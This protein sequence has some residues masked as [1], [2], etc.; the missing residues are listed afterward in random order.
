MTQNTLNDLLNE[1]KKKIRLGI[2]RKVTEYIK[3][4]DLEKLCE[5]KQKPLNFEMTV[6]VNAICQTAYLYYDKTDGSL[7]Q[8]ID[9]FMK[10]AVS[11]IMNDGIF[12]SPGDYYKKI[13]N[14]CR[15][16][17]DLKQAS[18]QLKIPYKPEY[19]NKVIKISEDL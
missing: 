17:D 8:Y 11:L 9:Y 6:M 13:S 18:E 7:E 16:S 19:I 4:I 14:T 1:Q 3:S 5:E 15:I 2:T 12:V 10:S